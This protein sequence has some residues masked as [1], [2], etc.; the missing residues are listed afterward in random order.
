MSR[1]GISLVLIGLVSL[2]AC[3]GDG[4]RELPPMADGEIAFVD[5]GPSHHDAVIPLPGYEAGVPP[6][7][8]SAP[9]PDSEPT[10]DQGQPIDP[11]CARLA[12]DGTPLNPGCD[13]DVQAGRISALGAS[14][15]GGDEGWL[16]VAGKKWWFYRTTADQPGGFSSAGADVATLFRAVGPDCDTRAADGMVLN[17]GCDAEVQAAGVDAV[18]GVIDGAGNALWMI[19]KG[20]KWWFYSAQPGEA[21]L[22]TDAGSDTASMLRRFAPDC[23][24]KTADNLPLNPGCD[25]AVQARGLTALGAVIEGDQQSWLTIQG[26]RWW[27]LSSASGQ[28]A[29][30]ADG[31]ADLAAWLRGA[32][33]ACGTQAADGTELNAGCDAEVQ[34]AG[35]D[36]V[37]SSLG[38]EGKASW[39]LIRGTKWWTFASGTGFTDGGADVAAWFRGLP[40][41]A[42]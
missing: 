6:G 35:V 18:G 5:G 32:Q 1:L 3:A 28:E 30:F 29:T 14:H 40:M 2:S 24:A 33:P 36:A 23:A 9:A 20:R 10:P 12:D 27:V 13:P 38:T 25:G 19:S 39:L 34:A 7:S 31:G 17:P 37:G 4:A 11:V 15:T 26:S 41:V 8:D 22:F 21:P 16:L 42:P